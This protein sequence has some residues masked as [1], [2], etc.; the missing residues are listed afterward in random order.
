M[1]RGNKLKIAMAIFNFIKRYPK[2]IFPIIGVV[3]LF[4]VYEMFVARPMSVYMGTPQTQGVSLKAFHRVM[5]N[6]DFMIGY[7]DYRGNPLWV[8]YLLTPIPKDSKRYKRPST[9]TK[10]WRNITQLTTNDYT[11]SG[12]DR[13]H[14]APNSAISRL[15][16]KDAQLDSFLMTNVTPQKPKLNRKI[17]QRLEA[18]ESSHFTK[19]FD[20][21]WVITGPIFDKD[22]EKLKTSSYIEIPDAFYKIYIGLKDNQPPKTLAFIM[23]QTVRGN[24]PLTRYV[25]TIDEVEKQT[26]LDF[27]P[28]LEDVLEAKLESSKD[29]KSWKLKSVANTRSRY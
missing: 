29:I 20:K 24:E 2:V 28:K 22:I 17:W 6:S 16:G 8:T 1:V 21:V 23:P 25:T 11:H 13:G 26:R 18:I 5:R 14:M 4:Y 3:V 7:S 12:Y 27:S 19:I 15:Y 10:D 9:F